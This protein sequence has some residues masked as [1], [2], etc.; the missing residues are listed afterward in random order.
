MAD[1]PRP[2]AATNRPIT[3]VDRHG[4]IEVLC[5]LQ[6][7]EARSPA[8][9]YPLANDQLVRAALQM[10]IDVLR[11]ITDPPCLEN[12]IKA[13]FT[14]LPPP[15]DHRL[16][17]RELPLDLPEGSYLRGLALDWPDASRAGGPR[18]VWEWSEPAPQ[19]VPHA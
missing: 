10:A 7:S 4:A 13:Q 16:A 17:R 3:P 2:T 1:E 9:G 18:L 14:M 19:E 12:P 15:A 5:A 8:T 6:V 11:V